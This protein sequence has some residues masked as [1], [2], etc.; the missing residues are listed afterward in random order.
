MLNERSS[1]L[2]KKLTV[3]LIFSIGKLIFKY[4]IIFLMF[5]IL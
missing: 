2:I 3:F 5:L 4:G 1:T